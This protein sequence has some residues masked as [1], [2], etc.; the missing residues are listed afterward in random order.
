MT[1][2]QQL[3][4][5]VDAYLAGTLSAERC[6]SL[7]A[8]AAECAR[9]GVLLETRTRLPYVFA[10]E[11]APPAALR[12]RTV[13]AMQ[14]SERV[15]R[16]ADQLAPPTSGATPAQSA[17]HS[18]SHPVARSGADGRPRWL[19]PRLVLPAAAAAVLL[20]WVGLRPARDAQPDATLA[21]TIPTADATTEATTPL[22]L[23]EARAEP[24]FR[25]LAAARD[26]VSRALD[27]AAP[28][29]RAPLELAL[30]RIDAQQ[31]QL[32][33]LVRGFANE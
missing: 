2:C 1:S 21:T 12:A 33:D 14:Q 20:M 8:H 4:S 19:Q 32:R 5:N 26:D 25:T 13:L 11:I 7:E 23:A 22:A 3:A 18:R 17:E 16:A 9:C 15:A 24:E 29:D 10:S 27:S 6:E 28:D 30:R 31:E